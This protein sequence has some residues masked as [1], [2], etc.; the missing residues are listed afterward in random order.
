MVM[1]L[2]NFIKKRPYLFWYIKDKEK[3]SPAVAVEQV[4]NFGDWQDVKLLLKIIGLKKT[5][6]IFRAQ[7]GKK[8]G[9]YRPEI[10][11]YFTLYF[12]KYA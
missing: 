11:N 3:I 5:A 2:K 7:A 9:N 10:K 1:S 4:L 8:R 12:K 6:A